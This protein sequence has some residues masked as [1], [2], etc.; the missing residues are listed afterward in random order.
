MTRN[1]HSGRARALTE[2]GAAVV[3]GDFGDPDSLRQAVDGVDAVFAMGTSFEGGTDA[4][5]VQGKALVDAAREAR[6]AHFV[7][8]SV[9]GADQGTGV[10][11][12]DSKYAVEVY[13]RDSDLPYTIV[14]PVYFMENLYFPGTFDGIKQ[15]A[16]GSPLTPDRALQQVALEDIGRFAAEVLLNRD[17]F[18]GKRIELASDEL[19]GVQV[20]EILS[21]QG[22]GR[23]AYFQVPMEQIRAMSDD[24]ATMYQW[25]Q[26]VGYTADIEALRRDYPQ[27]GWHRYG[28]WAAQQGLA[29]QIAAAS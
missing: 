5:V 6:V 17:A 28:D 24:F 19:T 16:Y 8:T 4:E 2:L 29:E 12:F 14:A 7:Y 20:A 21:R 10:P 25:F 11:H 27:V 22:L 1:P 13:L 3:E 18:L 9:A 15:G 23:M 26:D